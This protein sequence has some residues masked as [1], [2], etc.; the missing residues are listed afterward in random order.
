MQ[1]PRLAR[2]MVRP[3]DKQVIAHFGPLTLLT[4]STH[5]QTFYH[6]FGRLNQSGSQV[7]FL[8]CPP[9]PLTGLAK[10]ATDLLPVVNFTSL[11]QLIS[12]SVYSSCNKSVKIRIVE[13]W[14]LQICY[15]LLKQLAT[16][17]FMTSCNNQLATSLL[18][19]CNRLVATSCRK[20]CKG[21]LILACRNILVVARCHQTC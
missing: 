21:I 2:A 18:T 14:H 13:T 10:N 8:P 3:Q 1:K 4:V 16:S 6:N 12:M 17:L 20:P 9:P 11:L 19:T 7:F 5:D 15:N